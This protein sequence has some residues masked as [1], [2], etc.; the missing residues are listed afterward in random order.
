[1]ITA[2]RAQARLGGGCPAR[3]RVEPYVL[4]GD[5]YNM[6]QRRKLKRLCRYIARPAVA[7]DRLALTPQGNVRYALVPVLAQRQRKGDWQTAE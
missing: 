5:I 2:A 3:Y 1:M 7:T 6:H 4:A